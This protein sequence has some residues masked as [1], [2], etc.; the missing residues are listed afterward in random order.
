MLTNMKD[1][2][3]VIVPVYNVETYLS[4]C[5]D[6]ILRQSY[7]QLEII[8]VDDGSTDQSGMI[9]DEYEKKDSRIKVIHQKNG[10]A[11]KAKNTGLSVATGEYL[12]FV[13][14]D[15]YL[16]PL[17]YEI[18]LSYLEKYQADVVQASFRNCYID[19]QVACRTLKEIKMFETEEFLQRYTVDWTCGLLWDK[20]YCRRLFDGIKFEEGHKI[21][22]EFFTYQGVMNAKKIIH[23][24]DLVYNYRKRKS[25]VMLRKE[26]QQEIVLDKLEYL[27]K[28]RKNVIAKFPQLQQEFD[29][30]YL[31][32]LV[33][34]SKDAATT[35]MSI[36]KTKSMIKSYFREG[37]HCKIDFSLKRQLYKLQFCTCSALLKKTDS[38]EKI[39]EP[40]QYFD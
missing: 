21:D 24:P 27:E 17:A 4:T 12:S 39:E 19:K 15:D 13:D 16:E 7:G 23:I 38:K 6:S 14:S 2:I 30:H 28:R 1:I 22:D 37:K 29:Y 40:K 18:M 25:S 11:A 31:S 10:G 26:T 32:M 3:S 8:I 35:E 33:I 34:L 5:L 36:R 9:C 20:L